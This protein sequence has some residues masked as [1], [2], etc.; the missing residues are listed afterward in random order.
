MQ[1]SEI[2]GGRAGTG[3]SREACLSLARWGWGGLGTRLSS[4]TDVV[5]MKETWGWL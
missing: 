3:E 1:R 4:S 5:R 2:Q